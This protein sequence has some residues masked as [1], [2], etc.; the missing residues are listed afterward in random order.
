[1]NVERYRFSAYLNGTVIFG[2]VIF[3]ILASLCLSSC[4]STPPPRATQST[5]GNPAGDS[6]Y[7]IQGGDTVLID[8]WR[9]PVLSQ[10]VRVGIDGTFVY[11]LLGSVPA[12]EKTVDELRDYL[13]EALAKDY[14]V[15]PVVTVTID[16]KTQRF[17]VVGEVKH[18]GAFTLEEKVN[19]YQAIVT[20]GG[21]TDFASKRVKILRNVG[22]QQKVIR[23]NISKFEK[24]RQADPEAEIQA[25]DTVVVGK[26]LL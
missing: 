26:K 8:V 10:K 15:D 22:G 12:G 20:A 7:R 11:P 2:A 21:F 23:V 1:M 16:T 14:L 6:A 19:V 4:G 17:F 3:T 5:P 24:E 25:G 18:A 9:V 13:K